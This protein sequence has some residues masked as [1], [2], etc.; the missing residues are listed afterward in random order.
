[1]NRVRICDLNKFAKK[2]IILLNKYFKALKNKILH[3]LYFFN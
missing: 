1:M 2:V 3:K